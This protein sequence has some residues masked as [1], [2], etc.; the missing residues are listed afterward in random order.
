MTTAEYIEKMTSEA[1][2]MQSFMEAKPS[3]D[4]TILAERLSMANVYIARSGKLLADAKALQDDAMVHAYEKHGEALA[5]LG[6]TM[7]Q[8]ILSSYCKDTNFIVNWLDRINRG[9]VHSSDNLRTLISLAKENMRLGRYA[10]EIENSNARAYGDE[11]AH[12][13]W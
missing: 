5:K 6:S 8:K 2:A 7:A 12:G 1:S 9:L 3:D 10:D 13:G 4:P 11:M